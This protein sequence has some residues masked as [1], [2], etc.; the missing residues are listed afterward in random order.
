L[1]YSNAFDYA[2]SYVGIDNTIAEYQYKD[3][4]YH[5]HA[6]W[7]PKNDDSNAEIFYYYDVDIGWVIASGLG[8][9]KIT[10]EDA[11]NEISKLG[12]ELLY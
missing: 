3:G 9:N 11:S 10:I 7:I 4:L 5:C 6:F 2:V 12:L 1:D 8:K